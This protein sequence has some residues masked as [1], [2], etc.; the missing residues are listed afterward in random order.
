MHRSDSGYLARLI[1]GQSLM[2]TLRLHIVDVTVTTHVII[3]KYLQWMLL[4]LNSHIGV[5]KK[6]ETRLLLGQILSFISRH[7]KC[8]SPPYSCI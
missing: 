6:T 1:F 7:V 8:V 3:N 4:L 2:K 5:I